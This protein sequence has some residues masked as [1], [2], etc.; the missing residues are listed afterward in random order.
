MRPVL[1]SCSRIYT[2]TMATKVSTAVKPD[3]ARL[4][5]LLSLKKPWL[6]RDKAASPSSS[7]DCVPCGGSADH[8]S[9]ELYKQFKFRNFREAWQFMTKVADE[10]E[11]LNVR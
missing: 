6:M 5:Q 10:A 9:N 1:L 8:Q 11:R 2:R 7:H 4:Q 3:E